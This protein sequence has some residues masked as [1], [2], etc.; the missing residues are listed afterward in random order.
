MGKIEGSEKRQVPRAPVQ[1]WGRR[2]RG[3][4]RLRKQMIS[5]EEGRLV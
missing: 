5:C 4:D 1:S 3:C 2:A